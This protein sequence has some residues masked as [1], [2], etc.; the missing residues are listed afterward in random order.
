M[1]FGGAYIGELLYMSEGW[2]SR[3]PVFVEVR[4]W[5]KLGRFKQMGASEYA[6]RGEASGDASEKA[7]KVMWAGIIKGSGKCAESRCRLVAKAAASGP[8]HDGETAEG[9]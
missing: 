9:S 1:S 6:S 5:A 7:V 4:E 3:T 2:T 8:Q